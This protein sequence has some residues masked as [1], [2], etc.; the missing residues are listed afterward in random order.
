MTCLEHIEGVYRY[1]NVQY[2]RMCRH[3]T[4]RVADADALLQP[5]IDLYVLYTNLCMY[6]Y[7]STLVLRSSWLAAV[8]FYALVVPIRLSPPLSPCSLLL[9]KFLAL[10]LQFT[11]IHRILIWVDSAAISCTKICYTSLLERP[12]VREA[13]GCSLCCRPMQKRGVSATTN[14]ELLL[15]H[16]DDF[17]G[18]GSITF[19]QPIRH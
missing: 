19:G 8:H 5:Y 12:G 9:R 15:E 1:V 4:L 16:V 7:L 11:N 13:C 3:R 6:I 2:V 17:L 18:A 10:F 14:T